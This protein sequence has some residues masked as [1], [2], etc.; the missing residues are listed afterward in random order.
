VSNELVGVI[1]IGILLLLMFLGTPIW[2]CLIAVGFLGFALMTNMSKAL[3]V[4]SYTTGSSIKDDTFAV[5]P[6]FL[7][8]G[9]LADISGMMK[10]AYDSATKWLGQ[11]RGGLAMASIVGAAAFSAVSGSSMACAAVMTRVA[12]PQLIDHKYDPG[13]A[14][15]ALAAGGTL[16][17]L[18][19]PGLALVVY[20]IMA[21]VSLGKLFI[22]CYVPGILLTVMYMIQIYLQC[23]I[24]P[25]LSQPSA[26]TT[27]KDKLSGI[28]G[29]VP[30]LI[31]FVVVLGGIQF[32]IFT[33][34]EAASI[35]TVFILAYAIVRRTLNGQNMLQALKNTLLTTG[36][37]LVML[38]GAN[39]FNV[40]AAYSG[41]PQAIGA[42]LLNLNL[43]ALGLI[44]LIMVIYTILG[45]PMSSLVILFLTV[46]IIIP[47]LKAYNIDLLWFGVLAIIQI[48]LANLTPPVGMNL[49]VVA[50]MAKPYGISIGTVFRG[51][52]PFC[53][54][55]LVF[56]VL[57]IAFPQIATFMVNLM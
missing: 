16:G 57:L 45:I 14:T 24:S 5:M 19:P 9:E 33:P 2:I 44:I 55:M 27:W 38:I 35:A 11:F 47:V 26:R 50:G 15:G 51:S 31:V 1:G 4:L 17:N 36:M 42:W 20:A 7:L 49:Y 8:M 18:I 6:V 13:L 43:S 10:Q 29:M 48:E 3:S 39:I 23:K 56:N 21:E 40:F 28:Q 52:I 30:I 22:A 25:S 54:T 46:P 34:N 32:G 41:L 12:L 53:V 37:I